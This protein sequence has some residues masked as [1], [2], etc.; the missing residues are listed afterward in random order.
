MQSVKKRIIS[1]CMSAAIASSALTGLT[2]MSNA[3]DFDSPSDIP[4]TR[5]PATTMQGDI[6]NKDETTTHRE[7]IIM[8]DEHAESDYE[9]NVNPNNE[10]LSSEDGVLFN[11]DRTKLIIYPANRDADS[12]IIPDSLSH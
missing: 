3:D 9:Y 12:Y 6:Q 7:K 2:V 5:P 10:T 8:G 11:K 1:L 4:T